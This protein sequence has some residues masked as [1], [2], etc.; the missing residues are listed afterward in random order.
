MPKR[1]LRRYSETIE[2]FRQLPEERQQRVLT[3]IVLDQVGME[4]LPEEKP[5]GK[6]R[7][8]RRRRKQDTDPAP[9]S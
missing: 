2:L 7:S 8:R 6:G 1:K 4:P 9:P 3:Q 5:A